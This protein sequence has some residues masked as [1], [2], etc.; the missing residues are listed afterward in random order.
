MSRSEATEYNSRMKI[1]IHPEVDTLSQALFDFI[2]EFQWKKILVLYQG[3]EGNLYVIQIVHLTPL[4]VLR[5]AR[6]L[7]GFAIRC[8][9]Y[10]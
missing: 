6:I 10:M 1:S 2:Q 9:Y 5:I 3:N 4:S 7:I 8:L